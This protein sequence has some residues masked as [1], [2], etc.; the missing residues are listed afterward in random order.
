MENTLKVTL[1]TCYIGRVPLVNRI[2]ASFLAQTYEGHITLL[3]YNNGPAA[4]TLSIPNLPSNRGITL[5]NNCID[6]E[7][8]QNYTNTGD[9]FR[10][11]IT[12]ADG[13][14]ISFFDSDDLF[15]PNHVEKGVKGFLKGG[16]LAYKPKVSY[17]IYLDKYS[18]E[19]NN[20]EPSI[21]VE[22]KYVKFIGFNKTSAS[23]HQKWLDKLLEKKK[24]FIDPEGIPTFVYD[25]SKNQGSY[26]ISGSGGDGIENF[27]RHREWEIQKETLDILT[28][29][30]F[31]ELN[32]QY[33]AVR[34]HFSS[35]Q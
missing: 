35:N 8:G 24:I 26:K 18:K 7:T 20:L 25:W 10:D 12:Y 17:H 31:D 9:I 19:S 5:I 32:K 13:D 16:V 4:H 33:E 3:L 1:V 34:N 28:P 15:F 21:F 11:A 6:L 27:N 23:Y 22:A 2:I 14:L 29:I 30:T